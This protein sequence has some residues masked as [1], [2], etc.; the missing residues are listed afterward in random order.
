MRIYSNESSMHKLIPYLY[1]YKQ[2]TVS[3]K[4]S[5]VIAL[6]GFHNK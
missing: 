2:N 4:Y 6:F 5:V 3:K 1:M